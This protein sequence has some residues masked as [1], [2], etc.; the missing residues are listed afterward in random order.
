MTLY[1]EV[2]HNRDLLAEILRNLDM[3][4]DY[5]L[6]RILCVSKTIS[7][8]I[9]S[10]AVLA[11]LCE[12]YQVKLGCSKPAYILGLASNESMDNIYP[13]SYNFSS[14]LIQFVATYHPGRSL[15]QP[16]ELLHIALKNRDTAMLHVM[17]ITD[18]RLVVKKLD[19]DFYYYYKHDVEYWNA[20]RSGEMMAVES[21]FIE[22]ASKETILTVINSELYHT[23]RSRI[24]LMIFKYDRV[25]LVSDINTLASFLGWS[26]KDSIQEFHKLI[27]LKL[28]GRCPKILK[29]ALNNNLISKCGLHTSIMTKFYGF[30]NVTWE[31]LVIIEHLLS[32]EDIQRLC[33][34][35]LTIPDNATLAWLLHRYKSIYCHSYDGL[36]ASTIAVLKPAQDS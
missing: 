3:R 36:L 32:Q 1:A 5:S 15:L 30:S 4:V 34:R 27:F 28:H 20:L 6:V 22:Q 10:K 2:L 16:T 23:K 35:A 13:Q 14:F 8:Y 18:A 19:L 7:S 17:S 9:N 24:C 29:W 26:T 12:Q 25:D 11:Q 21:L 31:T 33:K